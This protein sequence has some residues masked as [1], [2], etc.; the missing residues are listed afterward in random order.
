MIA[1]ETIEALRKRSQGRGYVTTEDLRDVM[2]VE[3]MSA[4]ELAR[5]LLQLEEAGVSVEI[6][7]AL[8][9]AARRREATI[10]ET[11]IIDL[12]AGQPTARDARQPAQAPGVSAD[13][14]AASEPVASPAPAAG[15]WM[16]VAAAGA[17]IVLGVIALFAFLR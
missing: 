7:D 13:A 2:P 10:A 8:N 17:V 4:D 3:N 6:E 1:Q 14:F 15:G 9:T 12:P 5:V 16:F 11:P